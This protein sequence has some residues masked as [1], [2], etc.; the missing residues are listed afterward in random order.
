M[1]REVG[2]K[3]GLQVGWRAQWMEEGEL[4]EGRGSSSHSSSEVGVVGSVTA[5]SLLVPRLV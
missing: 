3:L 2:S 1:R 5:V 4:L